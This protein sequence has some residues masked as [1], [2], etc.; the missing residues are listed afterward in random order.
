MLTA[1]LPP[2]RIRVPLGSHSRHALF[3]ELLELAM[4]DTDAATR[5]ASFQSVLAREGEASTAIGDGLAVPHGRTD[6]IHEIWMAAGIVEGVEDYAAPDGVPVRACFLVVTPEKDAG[7]HLKVLGRLARLMRDDA[8][9]TALMGA[10]NAEA[11]CAV[12]ASAET[13]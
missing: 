10:S 12:L 5:E 7:L 8:L 13:R 6:A 4:P 11:F 1:L 9:R 2:E 3:R